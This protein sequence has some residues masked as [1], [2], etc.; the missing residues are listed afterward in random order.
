ML[1]RKRKRSDKETQQLNALQ[2]L[3]K[4]AKEELEATDSAGALEVVINDI[5]VLYSW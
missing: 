1:A 2:R 4:K 3:V 5:E